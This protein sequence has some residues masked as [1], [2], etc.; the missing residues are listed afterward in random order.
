MDFDPTTGVLYGLYQSGKVLFTIDPHTGAATTVGPI[1]DS[2]DASAMAFDASGTLYV[3]DTTNELLL[4]VDPSDASV[5]T[6]LPLDKP[7]GTGAGMDFHPQTS[8][9]YLAARVDDRASMLWTIDTIYGHLTPI[10]PTGFVTT[11]TGLAF[12]PEPATGLLLA[13]GASLVLRRRRRSD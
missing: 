7:V 12:T 2:G 8:D 6:S 9:L 1:P 5:L 13:L 4:T 11:M 3:L 10:G